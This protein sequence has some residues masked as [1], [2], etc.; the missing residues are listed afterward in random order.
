MEAEIDV[1]RLQPLASCSYG[2]YWI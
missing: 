2:K 1:V